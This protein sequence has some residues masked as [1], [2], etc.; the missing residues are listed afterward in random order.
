M[1]TASGAKDSYRPNFSGF[2]KN[3]KRYPI[4][5]SF[6]AHVIYALIYTMCM[7]KNGFFCLKNYLS[8][9]DIKVFDP[10]FIGQFLLIP[11]NTIVKTYLL[12]W[13]MKTFEVLNP[14]ENYQEK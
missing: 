8:C 11:V 5:P 2:N 1:N 6:E 4:W 9:E 14:S 10:Y 7:T 13:M 3:L 12:P